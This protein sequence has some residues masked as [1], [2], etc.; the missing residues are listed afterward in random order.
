MARPNDFV[1]PEYDRRLAEFKAMRDQMKKEGKIPDKKAETK[2]KQFF[3]LKDDLE[4]E[5]KCNLING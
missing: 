1:D 4:A 5:D 3:L 2:K